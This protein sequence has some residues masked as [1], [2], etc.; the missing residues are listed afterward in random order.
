[1]N[2]SDYKNK[3]DVYKI[4]ASICIMLFVSC[5]IWLFDGIIGWKKITVV[6]M[7]IGLLILFTKKM[8]VSKL[9]SI[10]LLYPAV[11]LFSWT[12]NQT[13]SKWFIYVF[14][15][16]CMIILYSMLIECEVIHL[17]TGVVFLT[18]LGI[19]HGITVIFHFIFK[20]KFNEI[21]FPLLQNY[22]ALSTA[23]SYYDR[24]YFFGLDYKPHETAGMIVFAIA[25]LEIW[26][27][28]QKEYKKKIV[29][30][31]PICLMFPLL[32]TG[33][34]GVTACMIVGCM[35]IL[36]TWYVSKKQWVKIGITVVSAVIL[37]LLAVWYIATHLDNPLFYR[38]ASFFERLTSG[39]SVDAGRGGLQDA[40]WQLWK[41]DKM[42]GVGWFQFNG[43]TVSRFGYPKTHSVNLDYLQFLCETGIIGFVFMMTPIIVMVRRTFIVCKNALK[44]IAEKSKLWT[45]LFAVF[46]QLFTLMYAFIEV[47]FYTVM[48]FAIYIFSCMIINNA[49]KED[50]HIREPKLAIRFHRK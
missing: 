21:Y 43:Y 4:K 18:G 46:V 49:Y 16:Y 22:G 50:G 33:K 3:N 42:W 30:I 24:G 47:P 38:F 45:I 32:L 26:A 28:L 20:E 48:Y 25:A 11:I 44:N 19:F 15:L 23:D 27:L 13:F 35:F 41:E 7:A 2:V 36:L 10:W 8:T 40:A 14:L 34:K 31:I 12:I 6:A 29:Y 9:S 37:I 1:M 39:Q 17:K 5:S